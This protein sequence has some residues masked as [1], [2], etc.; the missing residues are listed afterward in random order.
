M[1]SVSGLSVEIEGVKVL[2]GVALALAP[3]RAT[4]LVGR[5]GAGKTTTLRAVMGLVPRTAGTIALGDVDLD[6]LPANA[7]ARHGIGYAP[8]DRRLIG[9]FTVERNVLL[10]A[11][12]IAMPREERRRRLEEVYDLLPQ[13]AA[14]RA[15]PGGGTSGG[16]GKMVALARA[17]MVADRVL[18]LDEP[19]QG[20]APALALDYARTLARLKAARG[21]MAILVT[22]SSPK[23]LGAIADE[24]LVIER[25]E[26][27]AGPAGTSSAPD[28]DA[29]SRGR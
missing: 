14:M 11:I 13:V 16:Q 26:I 24:T 5:N 3:G 15:R 20:L 7:R 23:L 22:E 9:E 18:L 10:P 21:S 1:L 27:V 8:E 12:A 4:M 6:R 2:R 29:P 17:L 19:F 28:P 25:G